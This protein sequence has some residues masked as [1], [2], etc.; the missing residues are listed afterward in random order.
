MQ[1]DTLTIKLGSIATHAQ[2]LLSPGGH[3]ADA[4]AIEGLLADPEVKA[5]MDE[6]AGLALLPVARAQPTKSDDG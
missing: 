2:E 4:H 5:W 1:T 6:A 3:D